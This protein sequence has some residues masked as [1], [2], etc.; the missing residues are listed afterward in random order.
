MI[1]VAN[2]HVTHIVPL[3][4]TTAIYLS[5]EDKGSWLIQNGNPI[6]QWDDQLSV[7]VPQLVSGDVVDGVVV[8]AKSGR[9]FQKLL[10]DKVLFDVGRSD[11]IGYTMHFL[12]IRVVP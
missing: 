6:H 5:V 3:C 1:P 10:V 12:S 4:N 7:G 11:Y 8:L 9:F 2:R